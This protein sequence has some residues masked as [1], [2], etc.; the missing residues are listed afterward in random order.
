MSSSLFPEFNHY[1][2]SPYTQACIL[3]SLPLLLSISLLSPLLPYPC[4]HCPAFGCLHFS[5]FCWQWPNWAPASGLNFIN[6]FSTVSRVCDIH[7]WSYSC[8]ETISVAHHEPHN[9][10]PANFSEKNQIVNY[11]SFASQMIFAVTQLC[12]VVGMQPQ[13]ICKWVDPAVF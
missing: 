3:F 9:Q 13:T 1:V 5:D 2:L 4:Y 12:L 11:L 7:L 10:S 8:A 6:M